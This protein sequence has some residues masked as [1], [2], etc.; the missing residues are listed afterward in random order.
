MTAEARGAKGAQGGKWTDWEDGQLRLGVETLG[1]RNWR[2]ISIR[3]LASKRTDVQCL[4]RWQKGA[5][6]RAFV[7]CRVVR[8]R[9]CELARPPRLP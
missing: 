7:A 8:R 4:H 3:F 9:G 2:E 6:R 1:A 5:A